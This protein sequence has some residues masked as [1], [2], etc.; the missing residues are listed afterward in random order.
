MKIPVGVILTAW[1]LSSA[2]AGF[3]TYSEWAA[4]SR[5]AQIAYVSGLFDAL[6]GIGQPGDTFQKHYADCVQRQRM[7]DGQL[8]DNVKN[9]AASRPALQARG[10]AAALLSYLIELCG[11]PPE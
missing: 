10:V 8:T 6:V 4:W 3:Y 1:G 11:K 7:T 9:F 5:T 2:H